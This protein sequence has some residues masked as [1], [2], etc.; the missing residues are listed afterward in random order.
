MFVSQLRHLTSPGS[1]LQK[2]LLDKEWFVYFLNRSG[3]LTQG[4]G[5]RCQSHR[6]TLKLVNNGAENL[7][8]NFIQSNPEK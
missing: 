7:I 8:I 5:N 6:A 1:T 2:S 4:S 3:I